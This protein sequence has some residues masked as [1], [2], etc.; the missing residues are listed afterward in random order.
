VCWETQEDT[1]VRRR[2]RLEESSFNSLVTPPSST[3][4]E[5]VLEEVEVTETGEEDTSEGGSSS[6]ADDYDY[7]D[8][9]INDASD[10]D[11][12]EVY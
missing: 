7:E 9:L 5:Y 6:A 3:R 4:T 10:S 2:L 11:I 1:G 8:S 12:V